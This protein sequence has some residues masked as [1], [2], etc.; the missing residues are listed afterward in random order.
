MKLPRYIPILTAFTERVAG[1]SLEQ[2]LQSPTT[3]ARALADTQTVVGHDGVLCL[4]DPL[5]LSSACI[6]RQ[7]E[8]TLS[9]GTD[10]VGLVSPDEIPQTTPVTAI[11][12]S[13]QPLRH[14]L[15]DSAMI[16]ATFTGPGLLYAQ[17]Q[18]ALDSGGETS[19]VD[20]DYVLDVILNVVRSSLELK[21]NGIALIEQMASTT[22]SE[23]LRSHKR[24]RKLADFYDAGFLIFNLPGAQNQDPELPAHC[25][26]D[27]ASGENDIGPVVGQLEQALASNA[28]PITT[29]ADV[30]ATMAV[31]ELKT[32][33]HQGCAA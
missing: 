18:S 26:F 16:F 24:V 15:P 1:R 4:F 32:L 27:L 2:L 6:R 7:G 21:A 29:A 11:L 19:A 12:E 22:P 28:V 13:I 5:L 17:L 33:L 8:M 31:E 25:I 3:L 23:L 30:P 20:P 14:Q 10:C 9:P